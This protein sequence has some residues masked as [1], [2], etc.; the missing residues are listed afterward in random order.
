MFIRFNNVTIPASAT[1]VSAY[2]KFTCNITYG[3]D[4]V[5]TNIYAHDT[6]S[7]YDDSAPTTATEIVDADLGTE[8]VAWDFTDDWT[9]GNQ[10]DSP[11]ITDVVQEA[12]NGTGWSSGDAMVIQIRN[13]GSNSNANR[14]ASAYNLSSGSEKPEL[15]ISYL[16]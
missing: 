12:V 13:D 11:D 3:A 6:T 10:Y 9:D 14:I 5:R 16:S 15:H 7:P 1:I 4:T 2:I 8:F